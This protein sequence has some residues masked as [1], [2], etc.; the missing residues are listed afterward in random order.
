VSPLYGVSEAVKIKKYRQN[1][2][3]IG[4]QRERLLKI[5]KSI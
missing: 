3:E 2:E 5:L 1:G 4:S